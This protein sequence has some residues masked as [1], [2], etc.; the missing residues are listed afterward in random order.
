MKKFQRR[1][2]KVALL[3]QETFL[4][5]S[6]HGKWNWGVW[7]LISMRASRFSGNSVFKAD[8]LRSKLNARDRSPMP[9]DKRISAHTTTARRLRFRKRRVRSNPASFR[10]II[11]SFAKRIL[12]IDQ[13]APTLV[14]A[15]ND[16]TACAGR[17]RLRYCWSCVAQ[18]YCQQLCDRKHQAG[19]RN[20]TASCSPGFQYPMT[21]HVRLERV[22]GSWMEE[23]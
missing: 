2:E 21:M 20:R 16:L 13:E 18:A 23:A 6:A 7:L 9:S 1:A 3:I 15:S 11:I 22:Q 14:G 5:G 12:S 4:R 8:A 17:T 19:L 10:A